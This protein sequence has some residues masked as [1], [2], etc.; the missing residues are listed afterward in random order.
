MVL[1]ITKPTV[2]G[3]LNSWGTE[4]NT[5]LDAIVTEV[6][7]NAD[8]TNQVVVNVGGTTVT[9]TGAELNIL[10]GATITTTELNVLDGDTAATTTTV[11]AAD[12]VVFNDNGTMKQVAMSDIATYIGGVSSSGT[13]TSV[14][15]S[16]PTGLSVS[17]N[18]VTTSGTLAVSLQSGYSI[19]TNTSQGQWNTAYSWGDH[20]NGGYLTSVAA[21]TNISVSTSGS[22]V[23][24]SSTGGASSTRGAVGSYA[25]IGAYALGTLVAGSDYAANANNLKYAGFL[26][27]SQ[28]ND[29]TAATIDDNDSAAAVS[30]TWRAFGNARRLNSGGS[31]A[32]SNRYPSTLMVRIS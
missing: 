16:V 9:A 11:A 26:S 3:S 8:G 30:G 14:D 31:N 17:G 12:R 18:P 23:T 22:T 6:N 7:S 15:M 24:V 4:L 19:P 29:N 13:V 25:W 32:V 28:Y 2:G 20:S 5:A 1:S 10:D 21:G 27:A